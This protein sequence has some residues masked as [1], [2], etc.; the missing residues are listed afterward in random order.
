MTSETD[1]GKVLH[2]AAE[3]LQSDPTRAAEELRELL[4][5]EPLNAQAYRLLAAAK[6]LAASGNE[7]GFVTVSVSPMRLSQAAQALQKNDLSTAEVLLRPHLRDRPEDVDA[8]RLMAELA[9]RLGY[10]EEEEE[11]LGLVLE[12]APGFTAAQ[13]ALAASLHRQK[14][15]GASIAVID[16]ILAGAPGDPLALKLKAAELNRAGRLEEAAQLYDQLLRE[17]PEQSEL[18]ISYGYALKMLGR[19]DEGIEALKR[20]AQL[21]P[22]KGVA[23]WSLAEVKTFEFDADD[24]EVMQSALRRT[25]VGDKDRFHLHF[26]LGKAFEDRGDAEVA[27]KHY[28]EGNR[29][30]R[31]MI[32]YDADELSAY[33]DLAVQL[34]SPEFFAQRAGA[35][36]PADDPIFILG[37][38]R[39]G[40]T[41]VEQ[42]LASH[43]QVEG[44]ME[45]PDVPQIARGIARE[46]RDYLAELHRAPPE[47]LSRLGQSYLERTRSFRQTD[48]KHFI[49]K[50]PTNWMHVPLI[51][52]MLPNAKI[53]DTRRHPIACCFSNFKQHFATGQLF[54]Y[55]LRELGR[56]YRDYVRMMARID[57]V[58]PGRVYRVFHES[59]VKDSESEIRRLLDHLGLPFNPACL[60][61]HETERAVRSASAD[62]VR[63]PINATGVHKWRMFEPWLGPLKDALGPVLDTYSETSTAAPARSRRNTGS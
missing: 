33:V 51:L 19:R 43:P 17:F 62:Q 58:M 15:H 46:L 22:D 10:E 48:R 34:F 28:A 49:D 13:Y 18:W 41:L 25:G 20:A 7:A 31:A 61:F 50:M 16:S 21:A 59:L 11:L 40:S 54:S 37:M 57:E 38:T 4:K 5:R 36:W 1:A 32:S 6:E 56:Y 24:L 3:Q 44:T 27:F 45:L 2:H 63:R 39:S 30:R 53:I 29:L 26:A 9:R 47:Q 23:W 52:A 12:L 55:D 14:R 35:G 8:L 60:R 42:I